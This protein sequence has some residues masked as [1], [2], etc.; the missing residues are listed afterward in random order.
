MKPKTLA[1]AVLGTAALGAALPAPSDAGVYRAIQCAPSRN[2]GTGAWTFHAN[3]AAFDRVA[4]C[5]ARGPGLGITHAH[6]RTPAGRSGTW[7]A[8]PPPGVH[9]IGGAIAARG[10][11]HNS[12][13]PRLGY[14]LV[15][16]QSVTLD[17]HLR[18]GDFKRY[19]WDPATPAASLYAALVCARSSGSCGSST[20]PRIYVKDARFRL[21]DVVRPTIGGLGGTILS[22]AAQR[23]T[24]TLGV[25]ASDLGAGIKRLLLSVN[26]AFV[27][28]DSADCATRDGIAL[29]FTPCPTTARLGA[30]LNTDAAPFHEGENTIRACVTDYAASAPNEHCVTRRVRVDNDCPISPVTSG[31]QARFHF[32]PGRRTHRRLA[33]GRRPPVSGALHDAAGR[34]VGGATVCISQRPPLANSVERTVAVT[35]TGPAGRVRVPLPKGTSRTVYLTYWR[36]AERVVT[37]AVHLRV[38]APVRL[39]I[40]PHHALHDGARPRYIARVRGPY[41]RD[42]EVHFEAKAPGGRWFELPGHYG[43]STT[44]HRGI[45]RSRMPRLRASTNY[46]LRF[47]AVVPKQHGY[48]YAHGASKVRERRVEGGRGG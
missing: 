15:G 13:V 47:R 22:G 4:R 38:R 23:G 46:R 9:L 33:Y 44:G 36:D 18:H 30:S 3:S 2:A 32:T 8:V 45:A 42:R 35:R 21:Q 34:P 16:G 10:A 29:N 17:R 41:H 26:G 25:R 24:Q 28:S 48:P 31:T 37:A 19:F 40:K 5:G 12:Y 27:D 7:A 6:R 11:G 14:R 20:K 39:K 1:A 43:T